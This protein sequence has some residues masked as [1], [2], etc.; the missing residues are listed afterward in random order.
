MA[1]APSG[2]SAYNQFC[3]AMDVKL[4][5]F[6]VGDQCQ[7]CNYYCDKKDRMRRHVRTH[8]NEKPFAC[9]MCPYKASRKD[10]IKR[11]MET[12]R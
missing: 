7:Y 10:R 9:P 12:V 5:N 3:S 6:E 8:L 1:K 11:H 4:E 2:S